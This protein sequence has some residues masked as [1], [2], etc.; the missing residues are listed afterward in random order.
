[1][2]S[3]AF[4]AFEG[5]FLVV[6][7]G[8]RASARSAASCPCG[9]WCVEAVFRLGAIGPFP[10]D[11]QLGLGS[12]ISKGRK[13]EEAPGSLCPSPHGS[14]RFCPKPTRAIHR[15]LSERARDDAQAC[16]TTSRCMSSTH[17]MG[18]T[19]TRRMSR[20]R[21]T[22]GTSARAATLGGFSRAVGGQTGQMLPTRRRMSESV[23]E[24]RGEGRRDPL[25]RSR[26]RMDFADTAVIYQCVADRRSS[27]DVLLWSVPATGFG[28]QAFLFTTAL[29]GSVVP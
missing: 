18:G 16:P 9:S 3:G 22:S 6:A 5:A 13:G 4:V 26:C 8:G 11:L 14:P 17:G 25:K 10:R 24:G 7:A 12:S 20:A 28:A 29:A 21:G 23:R 27:F 15:P 1:M 2:K 19:S